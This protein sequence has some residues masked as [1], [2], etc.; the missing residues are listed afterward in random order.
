MNQE[1]E[2]DQV[3]DY[4]RDLQQQIDRATQI[5]NRLQNFNEVGVGTTLPAKTY[6]GINVHP[7]NSV[8]ASVRTY[9]P[10]C[11]HVLVRWI[12]PNDVVNINRY[13]VYVEDAE[14]GQSQEILVAA[15]HTSPAVFTIHVDSARTVR[16]FVQTVLANGQVNPVTECPSTAIVISHPGNMTSQTAP[17]ASYTGG[18][19][20][21]VESGALKYR[22]S[23]G[24]VTTLGAA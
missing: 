4:I 23:G 17:A 14:T 12:E 2:L 5:L 10:G 7:V 21:Y 19:T 16:I 15:V 9:T 22:G 20:L 1:L 11:A 18:G 13:N 8:S 3:N 6:S 24:T